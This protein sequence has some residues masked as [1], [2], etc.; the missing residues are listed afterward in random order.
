[1]TIQP[2]KEATFSLWWETLTGGWQSGLRGGNKATAGV[3]TWEGLG[4]GTRGSDPTGLPAARVSWASRPSRS[5]A[6]APL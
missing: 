5:V 3:G 6:W 1:M 2:V 4:L